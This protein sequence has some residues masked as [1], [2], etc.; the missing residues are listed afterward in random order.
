MNNFVP[1]FHYMEDKLK[2]EWCNFAIDYCYHNSNNVGLLDYKDVWEINQFADGK[3][4]LEVYEN[5]YKSIKKTVGRL[6]KD[7]PEYKFNNADVGDAT[8]LMFMCIALITPKLISV[9]AIMQKQPSN[10]NCTALDPLAAEKKQE[11][12]TFLKNKQKVEQ[13]LE[14]LAVKLGLDKADLGTTK[15][16]SV[17]FGNDPYGLDLT[18]PDEL[19]VFIDLIYSLDVEESFETI[20]Q[21][22]NE[23]KNIAQYKFLE[24]KDQL[25]YGVSTN[26]AFQSSITGL[27]DIEYVWPGSVR[28]LKSVLP[29]YSD[30]THMFIECPKITP[31]ELFNIF[32]GEIGKE[33]DLGE[34][35]NNKATGY[36]ACNKLDQKSIPRAN[37]D[38][39]KMDLI[40]CEVKSVD[41]LHIVTKNVGGRMME[42]FTSSKEEI[43]TASGK[44]VAQ[45]TY[46]FWWL[47][48]TKFFFGISKLDFSHRKKGLESFQSF[49]VNVHKSQ[50]KSAVELAIPENKKAQV[51]YVKMMYAI[52]K[53]LPAGRLID[54]KGVNNI[55]TRIEDYDGVFTK[56]QL[57]RMILEENTI[58]IDSS[59]F[60]SKID[61]QLKPY[62][63]VAGGLNFTE[64]SGYMQV[65]VDANNRIN[66]YMGTNDT[67]TGQSTNSEDLV[68]VQ[69]LR[70]NQS[71]NSQNY[72]AIA[73]QSQY[74]K[75]FT[76]WATIIKQ[77][78]EEGGALKEAIINFIGAQKVS[79]IDGL[80]DLPLHTMGVKFTMESDQ[81]EEQKYQENLYLLKQQGIIQVSDDYV[82]S[83]I[84]NPKDR[85]KY[86]A[87]KEKQ[88]RRR[89]EKEQQE[90]LAAQQQMIQQQGKNMVDAKAAEAEGE[91]QNIYAK[92]DAQSKVVQLKEQLGLQKTQFQAM[93]QKSIN[94]EKSKEQLDKL[95][96][97]IQ[98]KSSAKV[99]E[100]LV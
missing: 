16:S 62:I 90:K 5:M 97:G 33:A 20:L 36:C 57:I 51:A 66:Q 72:V 77:G 44:V 87:V 67:L 7:H 11:D 12:L 25:R 4:S 35:I 6:K 34:L 22:F 41:G 42:F 54:L 40:Y 10:I 61:G 43:K 48:N 63:P 89:A 86:L 52:I 70:L 1:Y 95:L 98:A 60:D 13:Q 100:A 9:E 93:V 15:Y 28:T 79:V 84:Q 69:K 39:F 83:V 55:M 94:S 64:I 73:I 53:A 65:I 8:D 58:L 21:I 56:E 75:V 17:P 80:T 46:C 29:D 49:S 26:R 30:V 32:G 81:E 71:L 14:E 82:L 85:F 45:N 24:C 88:F 50:E 19:Q 23:I 18:E 59:G 96:R 91:R 37:W 3:F 74:Q 47:K 99:Q 27:P 78:I 68:G 38:T 92:A 2:P 76:N 31:I